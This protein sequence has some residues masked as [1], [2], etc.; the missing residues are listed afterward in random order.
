M[1]A[2]IR[3]AVISFGLAAVPFLATAAEAGYKW[4]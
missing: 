2:R 3:L 1:R 4:K